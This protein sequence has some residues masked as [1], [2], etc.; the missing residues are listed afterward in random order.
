MRR[1]YFWLVDPTRSKSSS[2]A[3]VGRGAARAVALGRVELSASCRACERAASAVWVARSSASSSSASTTLESAA[4]SS[5]L[6]RSSA[7]E[8]V[9]SWRTSGSAWR[10]VGEVGGEDGE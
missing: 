5:R 10:W 8:E 9:S 2:L 1:S 6:L 3:F 4:G 7:R